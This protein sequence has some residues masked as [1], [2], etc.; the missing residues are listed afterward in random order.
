MKKIITK[1]KNN[2]NVYICEETKEHMKAHSDVSLE[3]IK[4]AI[5]NVTLSGTFIMES[6]DLGT[7]IGKDHCIYVST[8]NWKN[9]NMIQRPNRKGLT[10]MI[11][12]EPADTSLLTIGLCV[13]DDGLWTLFTAFYG[14]K[15]PKEPWDAS[16]KSEQEKEESKKFWRCHALCY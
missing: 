15:V 14:V 16:I 11:K 12:S 4:E 5:N 10:P 1:S 6:V 2:I 7:V 9:V 3:N 8:E 13:D